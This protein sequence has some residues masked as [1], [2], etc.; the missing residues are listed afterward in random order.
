M[1]LDGDAHDSVMTITCA[2]TIYV[3]C[4]C[5]RRDSGFMLLKNGRAIFKSPVQQHQFIFP[6]QLESGGS[7]SPSAAEVLTYLNTL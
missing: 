4:L 3:A 6:F 7:D 2:V 1:F 5:S